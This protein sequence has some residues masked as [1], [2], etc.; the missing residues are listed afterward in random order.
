MQGQETLGFKFVL[1]VHNLHLRVSGQ[2]VSSRIPKELHQGTHI[3]QNFE[4]YLRVVRH[5][6]INA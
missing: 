4:L 3:K 2:S 1:N 5:P 6:F